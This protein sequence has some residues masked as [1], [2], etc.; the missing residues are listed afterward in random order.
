MVQQA[1]HT[2]TSRQVVIKQAAGEE[3]NDEKKERE[4]EKKREKK[5]R[6]RN[7]LNLR[8]KQVGHTIQA[9]SKLERKL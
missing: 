2:N 3:E 6:E 1:G 4:R 9:G 8:A 5:V 7:R